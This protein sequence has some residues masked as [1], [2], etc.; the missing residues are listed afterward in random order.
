VAE[1]MIKDCIEKPWSGEFSAKQNRKPVVRVRRILVRA[2]EVINVAIMTDSLVQELVNSGKAEAVA[3][4]ALVDQARNERAD[5]EKHAS[6]ESRKESFQE[7][8]ADYVL[9]GTVES[10]LDQEGSKA[11]KYYKATFK[12]VDVTTQR[13]AWQNSKAV[14]KLVKK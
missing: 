2:E 11:V 1:A 6:A 3:E 14:K 8:G 13:I 12:L 7:V 4:E 5:Q 10:Q 9:T